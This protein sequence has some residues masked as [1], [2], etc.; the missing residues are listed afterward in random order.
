MAG[1]KIMIL[2][3][4]R[5]LSRKELSK[6][7]GVAVSFI[8]ALEIGQKIPTIRTLVKLASALKV[9]INELVSRYKRLFSK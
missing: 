6:Q 5:G 1:Q 2:C 4:I 9:S 8:Y 7:S 3:G